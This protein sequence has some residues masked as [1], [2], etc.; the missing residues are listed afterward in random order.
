[1][2]VVFMSDT[3]NYALDDVPE[4]DVVI[5]CGDMTERGSI[6]EVTL[7][8]EW[9]GKLPQ[10]HRLCIAGNHD[11]LFEQ[12]PTVARLIL[13]DHGITYLE[14]DY[15]EL[16]GLKIYGTPQQPYYHNWA[17]N[18]EEEDLMQIYENI[19]DGLDILITHCPPRGILDEVAQDFKLRYIGSYDLLQKVSRAKPKFHCFGHCHASYGAKS[20]ID[21][22]YINASICNER[23]LP[24][25]KPWTFEVDPC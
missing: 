20:V 18:R 4:G 11:F 19:P 25:N 8:A 13:K 1:M 10:P 5:H 12:N 22:F 7:F 6:K 15:L 21:T 14:D 2:K 3:H 24:V 17:F 9:F 23:Q 16:E